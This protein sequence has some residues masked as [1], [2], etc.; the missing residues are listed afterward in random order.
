MRVSMS[1]PD[2]AV[3]VVAGPMVFFERASTAIF[4]GAAISRSP[5][6]DAR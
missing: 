2:S 5:Q 1:A 6:D 4:I 3:A